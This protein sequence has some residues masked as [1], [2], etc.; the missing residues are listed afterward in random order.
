[1]RKKWIVMLLCGCLALSG[2]GGKDE[3][4][5]VNNDNNNKGQSGSLLNPGGNSG[6]NNVTPGVGGDQENNDNPGI[7]TGAYWDPEGSVTL[8]KY[9]G[10]EVEK[11][12][13]EVTDEEIEAEIDYFLRSNAELLEVT[14]RNTV[15]SGDVVKVDYTLSIGGEEIDSSEGEDVEIG[16]E[17]YDFEEEL[18]GAFVGES[19]TVEKEIS[20]TYYSNYLGQTGTYIVNIKAIQTR[21]IPEL[22]DETVASFTDYSTVEQYRESVFNELEQQKIEEAQERQ[23]NLM[24]DAIIADSTFTGISDADKQSYVDEMVEYY[25]SYATYLGFELKDFIDMYFNFSYEEFLNLAQE[26]ADIVI[27]QNLI[28]DAVVKAENLEVSDQEYT[29]YLAA[30]AAEN[31]FDSPEDAEN[32]F[33]KDAFLQVILRDKAYELLVNSMI[34]K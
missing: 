17:Y 27:K 26:E 3:D 34:V 6:D 9:L 31:S 18:I 2:C 11:V 24:F 5:T 14:D 22:T 21:I 16:G 15:E 12:S 25:S 4:E 32:E 28:Q 7:A 23:V 20:D 30:Y 29:D 33:G 19:K 13:Y 10:V 1:M 8:G